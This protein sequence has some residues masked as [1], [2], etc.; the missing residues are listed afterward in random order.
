MRDHS[1]SREGITYEPDAARKPPRPPPVATPAHLE[2]T[3][4]DYVERF[5]GPAANLRRVLRRHLDKSVRAHG[6]DPIAGAETIEAI[7][8]R[9][10]ENGLVDDGKFAQ[11]AARTLHG[12][13]KS[14][15]MIAVQ[16]RGKGLAAD[17][18]QGALASLDAEPELDDRAAAQALAKR[19][20]L[21]PYRREGRAEARQKDLQSM[22]RMGFAFDLVRS[23]IDGEIP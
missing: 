3:A 23:V 14:R 8:A 1:P 11:A 15:R 10:I 4:Q 19:R 16:L 5:W 7:V 13:G 12:R 18:V 9:F 21:G 17:D 2:T 22:M 20:R 6:T